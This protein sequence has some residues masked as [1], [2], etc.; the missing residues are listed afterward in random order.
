[1]GKRI[2][3]VLGLL[4][5]MPGGIYAA[6]KS[7]A[8]WQLLQQGGLVVFI[9]HSLAPGVGDP[10]GFTLGDCTTQRTLSE[11]GRRQARTL[12]EAFR[13]RGVPIEKVYSSQWC[14]CRETA[15]LA[16]GS[17]TEHQALNS[18][19]A[20]P[21]LK[22]AQTAAMNSLLEENRP[23]SGNL[24]LVTHQVNITA[25]TGIVPAPSEMVLAR[26][27]ANAVGGLT[28]CARIALGE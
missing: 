26:I 24:I 22:I 17:Y 21:E 3:S 11:D 4:L 13:R 1:M 20:Q 12:G 23:Q 8:A 27:N 6:E 10:P 9:R 18:F 2:A 16:F 19:F 14:R 25:L 7:A 15:R 5:L 28:V